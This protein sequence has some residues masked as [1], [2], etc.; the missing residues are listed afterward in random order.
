MAN[1]VRPASSWREHT[2]H[3][4]MVL[5]HEEL[6]W[7]FRELEYGPGGDWDV[8][9]S[10]LHIASHLDLIRQR[11]GS[12]R[13]PFQPVAPSTAVSAPGDHLAGSWQGVGRGQHVVISPGF[14]AAA[15]E[16]DMGPD[17]VLR[18]HFAYQRE[19][20][21]ADTIVQGLINSIA[22]NLRSG[23]SSGSVF[24]QTV[25][26]AI[27]HHSLRMPSVSAYTGSNGRGLSKS[28]LAKIVDLIETQIS[29]DLS[30]TQ[31][32]SVINV[33]T[34]YFCRAFR[35][36][37]GMSPHQ[38]IIKRRVE[39]AR[40]LIEAGTMSLSEVAQAAGFKDHSQMS[41]TFR[42]VLKLTPSHFYNG[43]STPRK[44]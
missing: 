3:P 44:M 4:A 37:T 22:L 30:L 35:L 36:S 32:S 8:V 41:A 16:R 10:R 9:S 26:L 21:A 28:Q 31:M 1:I 25:V 12:S 14:V 17:T 33:S 42:K 7:E 19:P 29:G 11:L 18:R 24:M 2:P 39:I 38:F 43:R 20:D 23:N 5:H 34:R 15:F 27:V 13:L 6:E 40:C